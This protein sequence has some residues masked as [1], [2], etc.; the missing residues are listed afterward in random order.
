[1]TQK[2]KSKKFYR[3]KCW[4]LNHNFFRSIEDELSSNSNH[5]MHIKFCCKSI[6]PCIK[7][8]N[9]ISFNATKN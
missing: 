1:M 3:S 8:I 6:L 2:I 5:K 7:D 4:D 9:I